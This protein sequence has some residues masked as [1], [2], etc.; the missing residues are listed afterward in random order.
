M[1]FAC[2]SVFVWGGEGERERR[3]GGVVVSCAAKL[4]LDKRNDY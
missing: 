2:V 1:M 4:C 3:G